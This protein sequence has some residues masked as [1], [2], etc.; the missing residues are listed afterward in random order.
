MSSLAELKTRIADELTRDD[1]G[2]GGEA[3]DAL[4][5]AI[6][7]A[8]AHYA[9]EMGWFNRLSGTATTTA[10]S[11]AALPTGMRYAT[12]VSY[13]E[14]PLIRDELE[15]LE[16]LIE[17]GIPTRWAMSGDSLYLYP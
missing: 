16:P 5:R 14:E 4:S 3:E 8:I 15:N 12:Q 10:S 2:T 13:L 11:T 6:D 17:T 1:M 7:S 9:D